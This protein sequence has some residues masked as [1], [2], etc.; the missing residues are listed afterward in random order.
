MKTNVNANMNVNMKALTNV[1]S[2]AILGFRTLTKNSYIQER[3]R[4]R[5]IV[6]GRGQSINCTIV[7]VVV[8]RPARN[9]AHSSKNLRIDSSHRDFEKAG[10]LG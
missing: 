1:N 2:M 4:I 5:G 3:M 8:F 10:H 9:G 6:Y 7:P